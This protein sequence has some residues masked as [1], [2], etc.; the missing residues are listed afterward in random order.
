MTSDQSKSSL[1]ISAELGLES[2]PFDGMGFMTYEST[3]LHIIPSD[4]YPP[5]I[6]DPLEYARTNNDV[7]ADA[8]TFEQP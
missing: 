7:D 6:T 8:D 1:D 2:K 3:W 5:E 4:I